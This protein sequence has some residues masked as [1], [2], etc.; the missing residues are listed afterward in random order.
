MFF[1]EHIERV[2]INVYNLEKIEVILDIPWLAIHNPEI[3]WK[4]GEVKIMRCL[5]IC[6]KKNSQKNGRREDSRGTGTKKVLEVKKGIWKSGV[7]K[8]T[9]TKGLESCNKAKREF[10]V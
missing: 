10:H 4:K 1:K 9:S 7:K 8:N 2:R 5:S 3:D 6:R